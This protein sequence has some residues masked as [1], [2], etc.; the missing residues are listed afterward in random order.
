M[1]ALLQQIRDRARRRFEQELSGRLEALFREC[2]TLCGF[3]VQQAAAVPERLTCHPT[4]THEQAELVLGEI[5]QMLRDLLEERPEG[6]QL[7]HGR[8][9]ARTLH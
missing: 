9:F 8:T 6:A 7:L 1:N 2:P 4:P 3:T 5:T